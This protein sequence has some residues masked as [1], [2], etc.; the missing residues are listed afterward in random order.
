MNF[1]ASTIPSIFDTS[2]SSDGENIKPV[3]A[4]ID[5]QCLSGES[6]AFSLQWRDAV[7]RYKHFTN[8]D[9]WQSAREAA[10]AL[11][12]L[13][14]SGSRGGAEIDFDAS[15]TALKAYD[16]SLPF[17]VLS[18]IEDA[19]FVVQCLEKGASG[20]IPASMSL[21]VAPQILHLVLAGGVFIPSTALVS[22]ADQ[23]A[24]PSEAALPVQTLLTSKEML[25]ARELRKGTP[26]KIIAY[27]LNMCEST[28]KVH[29]RNIMR[30]MCARNRTQVA[31]LSN[32]LF[33]SVGKA[34]LSSV[35]AREGS[36]GPGAG[37]TIRNHI[38]FMPGGR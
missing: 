7:A 1:L 27:H 9:V 17:V 34:G 18:D 15:V 25:I 14:I 2:C 10:C 29:V 22:L 23:P 38:G 37:R 32:Q 33:G 31:Y 8:I 3:F 11:L 16:G 30:K 24:I 6:L 21:A 28:V 12:I 13:N 36:A 5:T 4:I 19:R 26:N 20:Y 35:A